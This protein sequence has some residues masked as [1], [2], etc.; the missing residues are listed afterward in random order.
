MKS[1]NPLTTFPPIK[2]TP[3]SLH[4]IYKCVSPKLKSGAE[5][6][7]FSTLDYHFPIINLFFHLT[8]HSKNI[9][10]FSGNKFW[11]FRCFQF[12]VIAFK[13]HILTG[14][15]NNNIYVVLIAKWKM[16]WITCN[17][18]K[19]I[20]PRFALSKKKKKRVCQIGKKGKLSLARK[21]SL[22]QVEGVVIRTCGRLRH[23]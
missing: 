3:I 13:T 2:R 5:E 12:I 16:I 9:Y 6:R 23:L 17:F 21:A 11:G 8:I 4:F 20:W 22:G 1:Q 18:C 15:E 10:Y 19:V 7:S 14:G